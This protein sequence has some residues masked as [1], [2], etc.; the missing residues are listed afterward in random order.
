[1]PRS[2]PVSEAW[3]DPDPRGGI[4]VPF[5]HREFAFHKGSVAFLSPA[6]VPG[7]QTP[8]CGAGW[9]SR[10]RLDVG[11]AAQAPAQG[12]S[13]TCRTLGTPQQ[14]EAVGQLPRHTLAEPSSAATHLPRPGVQLQDF[15]LNPPGLSHHL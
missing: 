12:T 3:R 11:L 5:P 2:T 7:I 6:A 15:D 13:P 10:R 8:R 9:A 14:Q 1:M 4:G